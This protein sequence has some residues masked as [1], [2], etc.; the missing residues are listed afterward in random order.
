MRVKDIAWL[1]G[2]LDGEGCFCNTWGRTW[3]YPKITVETTD[4]DSIAR[5]AKLFGNAVCGPKSHGPHR[6]TWY[7]AT[8]GKPAIAWMLTLYPLMSLR[9]KAKI[10]EL[11]T[12][13]RQP[14]ASTAVL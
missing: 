7:T 1:A 13:W 4:Q 10:T 12:Q 9:R 2:Y 5:V 14:H 6:K 3:H 8:T 11:V